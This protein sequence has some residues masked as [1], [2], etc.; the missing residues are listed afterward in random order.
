M[1]CW[2][3]IVVL[4]LFVCLFSVLD[5]IHSAAIS[6]SLFGDGK[7]IGKR[8]SSSP[9]CSVWHSRCCQRTASSKCRHETWNWAETGRYIAIHYHSS[10]FSNRFSPFH[11]KCII[12]LIVAFSFLRHCVDEHQAVSE[13]TCC[14]TWTWWDDVAVTATSRPVLLK[15]R[16]HFWYTVLRYIGSGKAQKTSTYVSV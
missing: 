5:Q 4:Q 12:H 3:L 13:P 11:H 10:S 9:L 15:V 7:R 14:K 2:I 6:R 1:N 8:C 16:N